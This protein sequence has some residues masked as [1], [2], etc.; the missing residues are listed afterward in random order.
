MRADR[1][2]SETNMSFSANL[3]SKGRVLL[4]SELRKKAGFKQGDLLNISLGP[5]HVAHI[6]SMRQKI[7]SL[8]GILKTKG[9]SVVDELIA[10]RRKEALN[11]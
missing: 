2:N 11:D 3:D 9:R 6:S 10:E 7:S 8:R 1:K 5:D 4:P